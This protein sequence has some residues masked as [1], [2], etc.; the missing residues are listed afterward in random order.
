MKFNETTFSHNKHFSFDSKINLG[1]HLEKTLT[2]TMKYELLKLSKDG[3]TSS[4]ESAI[5]DSC[6]ATF[7]Y[8]SNILLIEE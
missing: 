3:T 2:E 4:N 5:E 7:D 8:D 1:D 6:N